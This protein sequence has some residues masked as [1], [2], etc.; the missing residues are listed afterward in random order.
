MISANRRNSDCDS[1]YEAM[2]DA[3]RCFMSRTAPLLLS[4][5]TVHP[6]QT[7][8]MAVEYDGGVVIGAD[9]RTTTGYVLVQHVA[10]RDTSVV[11]SWYEV[12]WAGFDP[13]EAIELLLYG[14]VWRTK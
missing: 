14:R 13:S 10:S 7:T 11:S 1:T 8:I 3:G 12:D 2:I 6:R 9:S 5:R 4:H